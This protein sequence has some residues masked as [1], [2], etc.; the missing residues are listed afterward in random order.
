MTD[1]QIVAGIREVLSLHLDIHETV[2]ATTD[3]LR[4]L[5]LDSIQQIT[6]IVELENYFRICF[7]PGDAESVSSV[8]DVAAL[9]SRRLAGERR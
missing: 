9:I 8:G 2:D 1:E 3:V 7:D 6:F 4:D 5:R